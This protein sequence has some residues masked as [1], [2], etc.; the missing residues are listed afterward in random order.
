LFVA[1]SVKLSYTAAMDGPTLAR[2]LF[3]VGLA[4][5]ADAA[6]WLGVTPRTLRRWLANEIAPPATVVMLLRL[7]RRLDLT[8]RK[9][10][11]VVNL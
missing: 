7:M 6:M 5:Q 4:S 8:A 10:S 1:G 11:E 3:D 9:V 2:A